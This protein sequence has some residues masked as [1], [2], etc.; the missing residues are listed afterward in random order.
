MKRLADYSTSIG[1]PSATPAEVERG[2]KFKLRVRPRTIGYRQGGRYGS[3]YRAGW[4]E[5]VYDLSEI[6][7]AADV[8]SALLNSFRRHREM[9]LKEGFE[10]KCR[11]PRVLQRVKRR[12][13]MIEVWSGR[14]FK[15]LVRE[16]AGNLVKFHTAFIFKRRDISRSE[17]ARTRV[18]G[19]E[20]EPIASLEVIDPCS[21]EVLQ[22]KVGNIVA[23]RQKVPEQSAEAIF[24]PDEVVVITVDKKTGFVFGTPYPIPVLDDILALRRL[25]ELV[26]II[27]NKHAFPL[28]QYKVGTKERPCG[29]IIMP[30][31]DKM[32]EID[33]VKSELGDMPTEGGI[34]TSERHEIVV[35]GAK[36]QAM[37]VKPYLMYF[38]DRVDAGLRL[39]GSE[40][41]QSDGQ[42]KGSATVVFKNMSEA[43]RDYQS[44]LADEITFQLLNELV[45]EEGFSLNEENMVEMVFPNPDREEER[46]HQ[47]HHM[48]LYQGHMETEE[49]ARHQ[50]GLDPLTDGTRKGM[51]LNTVEIPLAKISKA[52]NKSTQGAK[53]AAKSKAK[54]ANKS[55][56]KVKPRTPKNDIMMDM[57]SVWNRL[58][59]HMTSS[60]GRGH[61][62]DHYEDLME[63]ADVQMLELI[64]PKISNTLSNHN[65][66]HNVHID[67]LGCKRLV[68]KELRKITRRAKIMLRNLDT[69]T[70]PI[71][72]VDA[73]EPLVERASAVV[74]KLVEAYAL[75]QTAVE[76][77]QTTLTFDGEQFDLSENT[78]RDL[79]RR[80]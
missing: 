58:R 71:F 23:W 47:N 38:K 1:G 8:E 4:T 27:T 16:V 13:Q 12:I 64:W 25:E 73:L 61:S 10:L 6:N 17:G 53:G 62:T 9:M 22:N 60:I 48:T 31:G 49:E 76:L 44:V 68:R 7:R 26:E 29:D 74:T 66:E 50:M 15:S 32:S 30:S 43:V 24:A 20:R 18:F 42:S 54:P 2:I 36:D 21:M 11:N 46:A 69:D 39:S 57:L 77:G 28:Y 65:V 52:E 34:V 78:V 41:G 19:K 72:V 33:V 75:H 80:M 56:S 40:Q 79:A 67:Y 70:K 37:D 59:N 55:G 51:Y 35:I 14:S 3:Q 5:N 63:I 45:I